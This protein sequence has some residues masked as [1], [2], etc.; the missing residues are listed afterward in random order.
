MKEKDNVIL[1]IKD[2]TT[3]FYLDEGVLESEPTPREKMEV[4]LVHME[5]LIHLK[6]EKVAVKEMRKHASWYLKGLPRSAHVK[7]QVCEARSREEM[8]AI[9]ETYVEELELQPAAS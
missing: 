1:D 2:L 3:Y 7:K 9:L 5:R 6:G 4:A 8:A